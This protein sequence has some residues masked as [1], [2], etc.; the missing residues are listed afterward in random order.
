[1]DV[2]FPCDVLMWLMFA[3][4][5]AV[6]TLHGYTAM[7]LYG[8]CFVDVLVAISGAAPTRRAD[9]AI[10]CAWCLGYAQHDSKDS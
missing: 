3:I 10:M 2:C 7:W 9:V 1:M 8:N 6:S 4:C 5:R